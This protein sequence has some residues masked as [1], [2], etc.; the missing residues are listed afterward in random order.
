MPIPS[1]GNKR[2]R[3]G[4]LTGLSKMTND[5]IRHL[6]GGVR[7]GGVKFGAGP[8]IDLGSLL[9]VEGKDFRDSSVLGP[10]LLAFGLVKQLFVKGKEV[11]H[12]DHG[13]NMLLGVLVRTI[14]ELPVHIA[15]E[16]LEEH[17]RPKVIEILH[18]NRGLAGLPVPALLEGLCFD[19]VIRSR[20]CLG[21][22]L[23]F[24]R[25]IC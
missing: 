20:I 4:C 19:L 22:V 8:T 6:N 1:K 11:L 18:E 3:Y 5:G 10:W 9:K 17:L 13:G 15:V 25:P 12:A 2:S 24:R 16:V 23:G 21:R 14:P 7:F